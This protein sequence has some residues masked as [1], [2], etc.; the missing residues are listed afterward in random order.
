MSGNVQAA[1]GVFLI[2]LALIG[3]SITDNVFGG[4]ASFFALIVGMLAMFN[5]AVKGE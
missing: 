5:G 2:M 3:F 4:G 1:L